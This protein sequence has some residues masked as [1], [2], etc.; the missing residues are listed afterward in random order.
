MQKPGGIRQVRWVLIDL[1][2][3]YVLPD[4]NIDYSH[5]LDYMLR[6]MCPQV[7]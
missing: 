6:L 4:E 5:L 1:E 3:S 2:I 7:H